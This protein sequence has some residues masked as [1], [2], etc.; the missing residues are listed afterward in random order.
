[1][2]EDLPAVVGRDDAVAVIAHGTG[3]QPTAVW[4]AVLPV[5]QEPLNEWTSSSGIA[6]RPRAVSRS[7]SRHGSQVA[8]SAEA[9]VGSTLRTEA[10]PALVSRR[11]GAIR[12]AA[13]TG[14][15][16]GPGAAFHR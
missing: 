6:A 14:D 16:E 5:S 8:M 1:V 15:R 11:V 3:P 4:F 13:S 7:L 9:A 2:R 10:A 12:M